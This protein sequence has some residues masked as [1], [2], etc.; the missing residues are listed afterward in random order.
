MVERSV[1]G[2]KLVPGTASVYVA[3]VERNGSGRG[4]G[5]LVEEVG[6]FLI[7]FLCSLIS[8]WTLFCKFDFSL[9]F[10]I[11]GGEGGDAWAGGDLGAKLRVAGIGLIV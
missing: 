3:M 5:G 1:S 9:G 2:V 6:F 8:L 4:W 7:F 10:G 11:V